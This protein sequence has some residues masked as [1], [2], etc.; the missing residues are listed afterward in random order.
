[1]HF[2]LFLYSEWRNLS[3]CV[4]MTMNK[5]VCMM[6]AKIIKIKKAFRQKKWPVDYHESLN[7]W[8]D[9]LK[10]A[11]IAQS[12]YILQRYKSLI[13][14]KLHVCANQGGTSPQK[15][16]KVSMS[17]CACAFVLIDKSTC[18]CTCFSWILAR[19]PPPTVLVSVAY[20]ISIVPFPPLV[21]WLKLHVETKAAIS[22][23][24]V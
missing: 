19:P 18:T 15:K 1:M 20:L 23:S 24:D 17:P 9:L 14:T 2:Q 13:Y 7:F 21:G 3:N 11:S 4:I 8:H 10:E 16:K 12:M 22:T 5:T 6:L